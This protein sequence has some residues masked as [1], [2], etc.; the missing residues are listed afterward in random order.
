M[1]IKLNQKLKY[2]LIIISISLVPILSTA[3]DKPPIIVPQHSNNNQSKST[4][5]SVPG[6][7]VNF[8][9]IISGVSFQEY[10]IILNEIE[11]GNNLHVF[12]WLLGPG[13]P[14][15]A[16]PGIIKVLK[17]SNHLLLK[18]EI[19]SIY[20]QEI[21]SN[22]KLATILLACQWILGP[23]FFLLHIPAAIMAYKAIRQLRSIAK[24]SC[25]GDV[26]TVINELNNENKDSIF[27]DKFPL[28]WLVVS[29]RF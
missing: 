1:I 22:L 20:I 11:T 27:K 14:F 18:A 28:K 12:S 6:F 8:R 15:M 25:G 7:H 13:F 4:D 26:R 29:W 21:L 19:N 16:I 23:G 9:L 24:C 3:K 10:M 2:I 5:N 17:W